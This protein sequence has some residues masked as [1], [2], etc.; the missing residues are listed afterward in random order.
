M[1]TLDTQNVL[2]MYKQNNFC[3]IIQQICRNKKTQTE[4]EQLSRLSTKTSHTC[5]LTYTPLSVSTDVPTVPL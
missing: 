3:I 1:V 2:Y 5:V 4:C